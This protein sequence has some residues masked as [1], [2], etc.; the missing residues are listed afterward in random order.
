MQKTGKTI[1]EIAA[2]LGKSKQFVYTRLKLLTLIEAFQE[3][4][5]A[6]VISLQDS[7]QIATL[8]ETSQQEFFDDHCRKWKKDK[9]FQLY[10]LD[11][12]LNQYRYDLKG[13]PFNIKD[14]KLVPEVGACTTCPSNS[15]TLKTLFPDYAKQ[16]V[17]S[18]KECYNNKCSVHFMIALGN[19]IGIYQPAALLY[20]NQL[21]EMAASMINLIPGASELPQYN[22]HEVSVIEKPECPDRED[23]TYDDEDNAPY[24]DEDEF[25]SAM[26]DYYKELEVY[27]LHV[28]S[29][30]YKIA[31]VIDSKEFAPVYFSLEKP[32]QYKAGG[33]T[34]TAKEVQAAIKAGNA[35]PELLEA[36]IERIT[37]REQ[38]AEEL[39][40]DKIQLTVHK[41]FSEFV[42]EP[43]NNTSLTE[44][45]KIGARLIIYQSLDYHAKQQV[46]SLLFPEKEEIY[47]ENC[48]E[49]YEML[50]NLTEQQFSYLIRMAII[51]KSESKYPK[52]EAGYFL[53]QMA[54]EAGVPVAVIENE[55][56][57]KATDR[58]ERQEEKIKEL[59]KKIKK[60]KTVLEK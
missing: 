16:A 3:M 7:L 12:Y 10:N 21:T 22:Y 41:Q 29:G 6:N 23:F 52:Q 18:N 17:C 9:K 26:D 57:Q 49:V 30:H 2:R 47:R 39:D 55:Q 40:A 45:D 46:S 48:E 19:A 25:N 11:Y 50:K 24:V 20:N 42:A 1:D 33:Q 31:L 59:E 15:A 13:A 37:Q 34:V 32:R 58:K 35:S 43:A 51:A 56:Q 53:F 28:E 60:L 38:R 14:K 54:K 27:N 5:F 44:A 36:E 4:V 8:S